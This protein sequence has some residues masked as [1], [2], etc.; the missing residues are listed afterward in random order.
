VRPAERLEGFGDYEE[1]RA[2]VGANARRDR[3]WRRTN[4]SE[5]NEPH[6]GDCCH[7]FRSGRSI[8]RDGA[9]NSNDGGKWKFDT[10]AG[11]QA[12]LFRR[13]GHNELGAI[14]SCRGFIEAQKDYAAVG[15]DG[16]PAG[17]YAAKLMS[18]PGKQNGLYWETKED[19]PV[20]KCKQER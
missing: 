13:I 5:G 14:A 16:L 20:Q 11:K 18:D 17:I 1:R 3:L 6:I 7:T 19:D 10:A 15:H 8:R 9:T 2:C 12:L 4:S